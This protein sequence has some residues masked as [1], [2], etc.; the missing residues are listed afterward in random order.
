M[1]RA[2][3]SVSAA[4]DVMDVLVSEDEQDEQKAAAKEKTDGKSF[5]QDNF[6]L[7]A[8]AGDAIG[9]MLVDGLNT[10]AQQHLH[11]KERR[12]ALAAYLRQAYPV[13]PR[14]TLSR[15]PLQAWVNSH[16][17]TRLL[18]QIDLLDKAADA[19]T[20][21]QWSDAKQVLSRIGR[22]V[23]GSEYYAFLAYETAAATGQKQ[24]AVR[25]LSA[26]AQRDDVTFQ[27]A[28]E[29][30]MQLSAAGHTGDAEKYMA[31]EQDAMG[32][33]GFFPYRI[34]NAVKGKNN[35]IATTLIAEC[36]ATGEDD[37]ENQCSAAGK[38][39]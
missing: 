27:V 19:V 15:A 8:K 13:R 29:W 38:T 31:S 2:G 1:A 37:L 18:I 5:S 10:V 14:I 6:T 3:Y 21:K 22:P 11:S 17:V 26:A 28:T 12:I 39:P 4:S 20:N 36:A 25:I 33:A 16:P 9:G 23:S 30:G 32:N 7:K 24:Q 34:T 35:L